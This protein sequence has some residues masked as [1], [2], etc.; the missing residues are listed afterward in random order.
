[1]DK[2][3]KRISSRSINQTKGGINMGWGHSGPC[4][5]NCSCERARAS[6]TGMYKE[7]PAEKFPCD[8]CDKVYCSATA[9]KIHKTVKHKKY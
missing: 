5:N 4:D 1:M 6:H 2:S 3:K 9:R 7:K 8:L